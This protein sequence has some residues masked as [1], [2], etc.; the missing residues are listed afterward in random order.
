MEKDKTTSILIGIG[1]AALAAI[2]IAYALKQS[3]TCTEG[4]TKTTT[5]TDGSIITTHTCINN[6]WESTGNICPS[7]GEGAEI[8]IISIT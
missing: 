3:K 7:T 2:G 5:C 6:K 4:E 1:I 8:E